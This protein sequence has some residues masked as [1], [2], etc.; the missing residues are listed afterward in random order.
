M[1]LTIAA[2]N[3]LKRQ[4]SEESA[5]LR[6]WKGRNPW[7]SANPLITGIDSATRYQRRT[8]TVMGLTS[9]PER[10]ASGCASH[11]LV[12]SLLGLFLT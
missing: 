5:Q 11:G 3:D 6:N 10:A 7:P 12:Q 4:L 1:C 8:S 9:T 2:A